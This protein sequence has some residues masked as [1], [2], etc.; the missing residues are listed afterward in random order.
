MG[1]VGDGR[2][3]RWE[4]WGIEEWEVGGVGNERSG[5]WEEWGMEGVGDG[6]SEPVEED[7]TYI[8]HDQSVVM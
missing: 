4:E 1:G 8:C 2:S 7:A 3:G 6:R 5:G